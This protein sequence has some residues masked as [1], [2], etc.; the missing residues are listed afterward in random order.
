M[1]LYSYFYPQLHEDSVFSTPTFPMERNV[2]SGGVVIAGTFF[3]EGTTVGCTP[4][5]VHMNTTAFGKD[6]EIFRPQRWLEADEDTLK[7][8]GAAQLGFSRGRRGYLGQ[9]IAT[10]QM[11]KVISSLLMTYEVSFLFGSGSELRLLKAHSFGLW[12]ERE[13]LRFG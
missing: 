9:H 12:H 7:T 5:A 1:C 2:P 11:K 10:M 13:N 6:A 3:P 8:M 4:A